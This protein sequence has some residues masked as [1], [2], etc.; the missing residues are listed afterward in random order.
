[1][2]SGLFR[3]WNELYAFVNGG[4]FGSVGLRDPD[5][6]CTEFEPGKRIGSCSSDGHYLCEEECKFYEKDFHGMD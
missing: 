3:R 4:T 1:M 2:S 6:P 5:Y